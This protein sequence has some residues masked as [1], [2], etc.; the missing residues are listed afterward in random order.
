MP[1]ISQ[2]TVVITPADTD[3]LVVNQGGV[4][5]KVTLS[6]LKSAGGFAPYAKNNLSGAGVPGADDDASAGYAAGSIW[7]DVTASPMEAY[8]CADATPGAA[9]WL[10][11]TLTIDELGSGALRAIDAP[12]AENDILFGSPSPFGA[13]VKKTL[14]QA[15]AILGLGGSVPA[16]VAENDVILASGS[17]LDWVGKTMAQLRSLL[18]LED[19]T[20][21]ILVGGGTGEP[22]VWT[23]ATGSGAPVR[24]TSPALVTP[25]L[26]T[27][28]SGD[29][30]NCSAP[31]ESLKGVTVYAG[32]TKALA[33]VDTA[34][35]MTP[36]DV[37]AVR[38][39]QRTHDNINLVEDLS[40]LPPVTFTWDPASMDDGAGETS[41]AV[42]YSGATL[43]GV[44]VQ[45]IAP[46][47]L[48][49]I[50]CNAYVDAANSCKVRLQNETVGTINLASGTWTLQARRV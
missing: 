9:V 22:P 47:D 43:G 14:V 38:V 37:A 26:G 10:K 4:T 35:A 45:A 30:R 23:E 46:Y 29:L 49:G 3:E 20:T 31:T 21:K 8:H 50:I 12:T 42:P 19:A 18:G 33:G 44:S 36:A 6:T 16:P 1:K 13:W 48:Q 25:A 2:Y 7:I 28:A 27:P 11:T 17:P 24:Q 34:S 15:K 5:K 41:N 32:A 39:N 40:Y